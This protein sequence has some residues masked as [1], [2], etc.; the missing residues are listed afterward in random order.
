MSTDYIDHM[1]ED[2]TGAL[3]TV[4]PGYAKRDGQVQ[5]A[6]A[7]HDAIERRLVL[8]GEAPTGT[9]KTMA[10]LVPAIMQAVR[11]GRSVLVV[12]ANKALQE[13]LIEKDLPLLAKA[14]QVREGTTFSYALLKGRAN[15]LCRRE[16]TM[17]D[18]G[19]PMPGIGLEEIGEAQALSAWA[20]ATVTG[21]QSDAPAAV[22]QRAWNVFSVTGERCMRRA[23]PYYDT[24]FAE[25]AAENADGATVVVVNYDLFFSKLLHTTDPMWSRFGTVIFDE[26]HEAANIARRCFGRELGLSHMN[27]LAGDIGKYLGDRGLAKQLRDTATSF[28]EDV[29]R[30]ALNMDTPR[31]C[32]ANC[33]TT[34]EIVDVLDDVMRAAQGMCGCNTPGLCGT[35]SMRA[36]IRDRATAFIEQIKEFAGQLNETTAYWIDKPADAGR[37]TLATVRLRAVPYRVGKYLSERIFQKYPAVIC[38]SATLTSGGTFDFIRE[39]LGLV[40]NPIAPTITASTDLDDE[41]ARVHSWQFALCGSNDQGANV[42][43]LRV[44][45]PFNFATQ[46]KFIVPLGIPFPIPENEDIY[47]QK[48]AEAI[49]TLIKD[50]KGRTL[51]L[52]TSWRR[53]KYVAERLQ[54]NIDY[55]LLVQGDA[56]NKMLAHMFREQT[57]SVLL[58]TKSFWVGLD[59]QGEALS[60]L[61]IDKLPLESFS[62]PLIDMMKQ[63]HPETFWE[64]FYFPRAAIELAQ[65]AG[66]L[67]RSTSDRGVFVLLDTRVIGKAYGGMMRRSLPFVGFSKNLADAGKFLS[68]R[69]GR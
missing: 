49:K 10:Y 2:F 23:C 26:A 57:D 16:M 48:A 19:A 65:G 8:L 7:V 40:R 59:I 44:P 60:C 25:R 32:E 17:F 14:L 35:C 4:I 56:P 51:A 61:V 24:C 58:A 69:G 39:E 27:Q 9:G 42:I 5:L 38:V 15:Y 31:V 13:Q 18:S 62:D 28:F 43:G 33:V 66:R 68:D 20:V 22:S 29:A 53:L 63:K 67:I 45:S 64:D 46:A 30:Y 41:D 12:T 21:D 55:P 36:S 11:M 50:C 34:V 1:F 3:A 54:G 6:H 47:N 52:F 37:T